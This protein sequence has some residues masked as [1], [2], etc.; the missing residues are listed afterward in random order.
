MNTITQRLLILV[1]VISGTVNAG[2]KIAI[3]SFELN[4]ITSLP[5]TMAE[6]ERTASITPLLVQSIKQRGDY[7]IIK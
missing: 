6:R 7:E 1:I 2:E 4:D 5:N 3:L